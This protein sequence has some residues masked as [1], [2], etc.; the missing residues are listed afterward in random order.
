M[1]ECCVREKTIREYIYDF[2]RKELCHDYEAEAK[3]V[4]AMYDEEQK[5]QNEMFARQLA[6]MEEALAIK[7]TVIESL[8]LRI[9]HMEGGR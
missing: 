5:R 7:N 4:I 8:A 1:N 3:R 9:Q 6:K 2:G